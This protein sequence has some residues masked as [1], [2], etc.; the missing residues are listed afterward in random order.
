MV[1][2]AGLAREWNLRSAVDP[3]LELRDSA[4]YAVSALLMKLILA[5]YLLRDDGLLGKSLIDYLRL[6]A[7]FEVLYPRI[8]IG[9]RRL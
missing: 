3:R 4:I 6:D 9:G 7:I 2:A 5:L 1:V 8:E